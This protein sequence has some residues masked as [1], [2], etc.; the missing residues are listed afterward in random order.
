MNRVVLAAVLGLGSSSAFALSP[1][2]MPWKNADAP[3]AV[4]KSSDHPNGIFVLEF[5]ANFCS[6]CNR[7]A[8]NVDEMATYYA[9]EKRVQV[10]DVSIDTKDTEIARW[11]AAH[12]PNHPVLKDVGKKLWKEL[13]GEYIPTVAVTD[14]N[15]RIRYQYVDFWTAAVKAEIKAT[16]DQLLAETC[17]PN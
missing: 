14:C 12:H 13:G 6:D 15:G 9:D 4:Y 1:F 2:E 10:L 3:N 11:I 16:V 7:N 5:L 17:V 8:P